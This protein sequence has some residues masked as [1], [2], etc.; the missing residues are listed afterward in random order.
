MGR[1]TERRASVFQERSVEA[2]TKTAR[3]AYQASK[4][5]EMGR[6]MEKQ[7][8]RFSGASSRGPARRQHAQRTNE[9][10]PK[11]MGR[12]TERQSARFSGTSE[13]SL[14]ALSVAEQPLPKGKRNDEGRWLFAQ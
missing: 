11:E 6:K 9:S 1:K 14:V 7:S 4:S 10:R 5:K 3:A 12:K 2:R 13:K 8:A